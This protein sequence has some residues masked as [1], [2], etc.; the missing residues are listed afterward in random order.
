MS[1]TPD[2]YDGSKLVVA[3]C[4]STWEL[5]YQFARGLF[6]VQYK[7]MTTKQRLA[8]M[9]ARKNGYAPG[10]PPG[11]QISAE[12]AVTALLAG[13]VRSNRFASC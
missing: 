8:A 4:A 3:R 6:E 12:E 11:A 1:V 9:A 10:M 7:G 13:E 5:A 2:V